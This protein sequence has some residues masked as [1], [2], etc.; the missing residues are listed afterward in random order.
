[1]LAAEPPLRPAPH[2]LG[3][4]ELL[5]RQVRGVHR[6][7]GGGHV[8]RAVA[9]L[10]EDQPS[11]TVDELQPG[12]PLGDVPALVGGRVSAVYSGRL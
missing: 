4:G 6:G 10:G 1:V 8:L 7:G 9:V 3:P 11:G 2:H 12:A 5:E